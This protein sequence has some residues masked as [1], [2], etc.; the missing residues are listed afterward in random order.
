MA[1]PVIPT[2]TETVQADSSA[3]STSNPLQPTIEGLKLVTGAVLALFAISI[4]LIATDLYKDRGLYDKFDREHEDFYTMNE[5]LLE[6]KYK[7]DTQH[8]KVL[9]LEDQLS[10]QQAITN[11]LKSKYYWQYNQCFK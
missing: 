11:C 1:D 3:T 4:F 7:L 2:T 6:Q 9:K 5:K 10:Q 8:D